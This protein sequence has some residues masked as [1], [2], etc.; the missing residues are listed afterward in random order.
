LAELLTQGDNPQ[1]ATAMVNRMWSHF[2]G[3]GFTNPVDDMGGHKTASHPLLMQELSLEF[4][5]SGYDL[6]QLTRWIVNS[7]AYQLASATD[8]S[9]EIDNPEVGEI[10]LF[11]HMYIKAMSPEQV[12]DS[13]MVAAEVEQP[14]Q[15]A[16]EKRQRW[17]QQFIHV[18]ETEE[19]D[20]SAD[21][22]GT[23]PQALMMMNGQL[24]Q[25]AVHLKPG[26]FLSRVTREKS[27]LE[28]KIHTIARAAVSRK[29]TSDELAAVKRLIRDRRTKRKQ[30]MQQA[31]AETLQDLMWAYLNS[32]EF[33][34]IH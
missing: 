30:P 24:I 3:Y 32:S 1:L 34:L 20:E 28:A 21:F 33:I 15:I 5:R 2:F 13:V 22:D 26:S 7:E 6:K 23:I 14:Y 12:Y 4:V 31:T 18:Y 8:L 25:S 19:N 17:I 16:R 10:P 29:A 11:S 9:N 27:P